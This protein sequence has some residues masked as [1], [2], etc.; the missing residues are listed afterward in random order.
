MGIKSGSSSSYLINTD[1]CLIIDYHLV[2]GNHI[3][4]VKWYYSDNLSNMK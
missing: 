1:T 3:Q 2:A 4:K